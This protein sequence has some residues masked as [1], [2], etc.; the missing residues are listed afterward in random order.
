MTTPLRRLAAVVL[1]LTLILPSASFSATVSELARLPA[2]A[3]PLAPLAPLT[4][5]AS[6][7]LT[8]P[9]AAASLS[10]RAAAA[11]ESVVALNAPGLSSVRLQEGGRDA[12]RAAVGGEGEVPVT[13]VEETA[14]AKTSVAPRLSRTRFAAV[15]T[16]MTAAPTA[17]AANV[18][19]VQV[20]WHDLLGP[21]AALV[22]VTVVASIA[23]VAAASGA[24]QF[25]QNLKENTPPDVSPLSYLPRYVAARW[26]RFRDPVQ[27]ALVAQFKQTNKTLIAFKSG[28]KSPAD[29][30][31]V[32]LGP[33]ET[34]VGF[35]RRQYQQARAQGALLGET[36]EA[37]AELKKAFHEIFLKL[38]GSDQELDYANWFGDENGRVDFDQSS[39]SVAPHFPS[40]LYKS[41]N[42]MLKARYKIA[43]VTNFDEDGMREHPRQSDI[44]V[45]GGVTEE[46]VTSGTFF[47]ENPAGR[48][49][50]IAFDARR[51]SAVVAAPR[52]SRADIAAF[53]K[54]LADWNEQHHI[55]RGQ[56]LTYQNGTFRFLSGIRSG[57]TW[58]DYIIDPGTRDE[59][60]FYTTKWLDKLEKLEKLGGPSTQELK[61]GL[62]LYGGKGIGKTMLAHVLMSELSGR[63]SFINVTATSISDI[64]DVTALFAGARELG[65]TRLPVIIH[66]AEF[67]T[68]G[69]VA[70]D[71]KESRFLGQI[72]EEMEGVH[73][74]NGMLV[75]GTSNLPPSKMDSALFRP[76]RFEFRLQIPNPNVETRR[77]MLAQYF[78][79]IPLEASVRLDEFATDDYTKDFIPADIKQLAQLAVRVAWIRADSDDAEVSASDIERAIKMIR[80]TK[81]RNE[82]EADPRTGFLE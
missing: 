15:T 63:A 54:D 72:L 47:V 13:A 45:S 25:W 68:L 24:Q 42:D 27:R 64:D 1:A 52:S 81:T 65:R 28:I 16:A 21:L 51:H 8:T 30:I 50:A 37:V 10:I 33:T 34:L 49:L 5:P 61:S 29:R 32:A 11:A 56:K 18:G 78:K 36:V 17:F 76:G 74:N 82:V 26:R 31:G 75:I 6:G 71:G 46:M 79:G 58:N 59:I 12:F 60:E 48:R 73:S 69:A 41:V 44:E 38:P 7:G 3:V 4:A 40:L 39:Q 66:F 80:L 67:D 43:R 22:G 23:V 55:Y 2:T 19:G 57:L 62:F 35:I 53:F 70:R 14:S 20:S 77:R 9:A